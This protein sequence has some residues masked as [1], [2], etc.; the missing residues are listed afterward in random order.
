MTGE[1]HLG[2]KKHHSDGP[3]YQ[4]SVLV[5][6]SKP[7]YGLYNPIEITTYVILL[8]LVGRP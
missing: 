7:I 6:S 3:T 4:F 1:H 8:A 5:T 2:V